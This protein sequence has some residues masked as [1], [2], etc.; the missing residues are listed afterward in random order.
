VGEV[1]SGGGTGT[2]IEVVIPAAPAAAPKTESSPGDL[3]LKVLGAV[4][5]G[6]GI[7][8]F[9]TL[10]GAALIWVRAEKAELPATEAV[11]VVPHNVLV[12]TGATFLLPAALIAAG[13]VALVFL[14]HLLFQFGDEFRYHLKAKRKQARTQ[15][16]R[17]A[18]TARTAV[19]EQQ[20]WKVAEAGL[21]RRQSELDAAHERKAPAAEIAPLEAAF[22]EKKIEAE[23]LLEACEHSVSAAATAKASADELTEEEEEKLERSDLQWWLEL[24]LAGVLL[25]VLVPV[26]NGL[27]RHLPRA[28]DDWELGLLVLAAVAGTAITLLVYVQT[29]R[30]VWFGVVAFL[31]AGIYLATAT[32]FSTHRNPKLQAV[33]ALRPGHDPV[34]GSYIAA[35]SE[36]LYVGTFREKAAPPRLVVVPRA[37]I[38]EFVIGPPLETGEAHRRAFTMA[39]NECEKMVLP[40]EPEA[41]VDEASSEQAEAGKEAAKPPTAPAGKAS[42]KQKPKP[43]KA[44]TRSQITALNG[45]LNTVNRGLRRAQ[46][47]QPG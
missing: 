19:T 28:L 7:I 2:G 26:V 20:V 38:A 15:R 42:D 13:V 6:I 10:F 8:G 3:V 37:Q 12:T 5:T 41:P 39:I 30:F 22:R 36:S 29:E 17:S 33:A 31:S 14:L 4:G 43:E 35:T 40:A 34:V 46:L 1:E 44:C 47:D 11:S 25:I 9:V 27:I 18:K 16:Q 23:Q 24:G 32:Y 45:K 21:Q